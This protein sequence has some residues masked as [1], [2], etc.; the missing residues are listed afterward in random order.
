ME[1][2]TVNRA[3]YPPR[4]PRRARRNQARFRLETLE[5][6]TLLTGGTL[7][8]S[9]GRGTGVAAAQVGTDDAGTAVAVNPQADPSGNACKMVEAGYAWNSTPR[10]GFAVARFNPDGSRDTSFGVGSVIT[11]IGA[12]SR[13]TSLAIQ[14]DGKVLVGGFTEPSSTSS[15]EDFTLARYNP[16]G[17][18]DATFGTGG[19]AVVQPSSSFETGRFVGLET[20]NGTTRIVTVGNVNNAVMVARFTP[21]GALDASFGTGGVVIPRTSPPLLALSGAIQPDRKV[22]AVGSFSP[23]SSS[24]VGFGLARFNT[25][26][27]LDTTF[28]GT[29]LVETTLYPGHGG[30]SANGVVVQPDGAIVIGG[31]QPVPVPNTSPQTYTGAACLVRY[32]PTG[33]LDTTFGAAGTGVVLTTAGECPIPQAL[34]LQPDGALVTAGNLDN[35]STSEFAL[36]R[37]LGDPSPGTT[38]ATAS[39]SR[40]PTPAPT[41]AFAGSLIVPEA[42]GSYAFLDSLAIGK[43]RHGAG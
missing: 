17:T 12:L 16:N 6:R 18:L 15:G 14:A 27:G 5:G 30:G 24:S 28:N 35:G 13:V 21:S 4:H 9:F 38:G 26:G 37:Y 34:A 40:T 36:A 42:V 7:D 19:A 43:R 10:E 32:T 33:Q 22:L 20:V 25:D 1:P 31:N 39:I 3:P 2:L 11:V 8:P 29:G 23:P 41:T